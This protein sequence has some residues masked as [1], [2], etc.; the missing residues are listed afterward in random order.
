[1]AAELAPAA[2]LPAV[3][4][5]RGR[6]LIF[7]IELVA[8]KVTREPIALAGESVENVVRR[9]H[10]VIVREVGPVVALSPP[11]VMSEEQARRTAGAVRD[12]LSRLHPDG[13]I[14]GT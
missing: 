12:V 1:M 4:D 10:G 14:E 9:E 8:D 5:V 2:D 13:T 7:G 3:G 11:L 6:G